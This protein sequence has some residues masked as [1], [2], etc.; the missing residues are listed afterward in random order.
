ALDRAGE[1]GA[2]AGRTPTRTRWLDAAESAGEGDWPRT[3]A[4][5]ARIGSLPDEALARTRAAVDLAAAGRTG[6]AEAELAHAAAFYREAGA[7]APALA[8]AK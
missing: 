8:P 4:I 1:L 6:E 3:A 2:T 7:P 5:F